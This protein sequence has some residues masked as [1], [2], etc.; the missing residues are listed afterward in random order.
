MMRRSSTGRLGV[1][2]HA[3]E[4]APRR[5]YAYVLG[6]YLGDGCIT[7]M[8]RSYWL[9]IT[10]DTAY[11]GII[12]ECRQSLA[13]LMPLNTVSV[14]KR[15]Y[16]CVDVS[17]H[18]VLWPDII[19]QH[20]RG[21][22]HLRS[23]VLEDWQRRVIEAEPRAFIRGLFHSDGS[24][25]QNPVRSAKGVLYT[26]DRYLF[27]NKSEDIKAMFCWACDLVG[28]ETRRVGVKAISVARR[29]SVARLNDFL[30]PKR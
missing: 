2:A 17:C 10:L 13:T 30:G 4:G 3:W 21:P 8:H 24:Y 18:S 23:I 12:E 15:P 26:Y 7:K 14:Y 29:A 1:L 6:M 22:K 5:E 27:S 9:R 11:P 16:R 19:P 25:F 28:V 20:G